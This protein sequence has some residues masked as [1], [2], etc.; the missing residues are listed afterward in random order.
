MEIDFRTPGTASNA[1]GS[2]DAEGDGFN[3]EFGYAHALGS[4]LT[5][6]PVLQ[7]ASVSMDL[8]DFTT[9]DGVYDLGDMGGEHSL[10]RAGLSMFKTFETTNGSITPLVDLSYLDAMDADSGLASNGILF[11][12]DSAGSGYRAELGIGGRYKGWDIAG[13]V[14]FAETTAIKSALS[15]NLTVR[16]RW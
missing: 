8:D 14:G 4:G 7:Y 5:F 12:N 16:Y 15:S 11:D 1:V 13:R 9:S 10:L 6:A 3:V 2:T